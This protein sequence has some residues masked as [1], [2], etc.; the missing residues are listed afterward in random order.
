[1]LAKVPTVAQAELRAEFW[2][3]FDDIEAEPGQAAVAV[4]SG[5]I[6]AFEKRAGG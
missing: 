1:M 5:R 2:K 3:I 6:A 4:A